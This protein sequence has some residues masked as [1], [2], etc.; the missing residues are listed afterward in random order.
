MIIIIVAY[1]GAN[2]IFLILITDRHTF[3]LRIEIFNGVKFT[4]KYKYL[5]ILDFILTS[6]M[7]GKLNMITILRCRSNNCVITKATAYRTWSSKNSLAGVKRRRGH[8][9][10]WE[11]SNKWWWNTRGTSSMFRTWWILSGFQT[12]WQILWLQGWKIYWKVMPWWISLQRFQPTTW[13][14][15]SSVWSWLF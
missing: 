9:A 8:F 7:T 14:V 11:W 6:F 10:L 2:E 13:K 4:N 12:M 1:Y 15:W 5:K 3:K